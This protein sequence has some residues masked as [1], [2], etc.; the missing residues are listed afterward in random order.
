MGE[1]TLAV[2]DT[3]LDGIKETLEDVR[4]KVDDLNDTVRDHDTRI[5]R[6]EE[7][8]TTWSRLQAGFTVVASAIAAFLGSQK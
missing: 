8:Q 7:R 1:I 5:V 3:K 4:G 6:I 2:L